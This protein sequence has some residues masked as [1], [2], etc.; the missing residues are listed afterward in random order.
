MKDTKKFAKYMASCAAV[1]D[2][3][4]TDALSEIYWQALQSYSDE[5][6]AAAFE[7]CIRLC[8]FFPKP[9]EIIDRID[10]NI[11]T[12][13]AIAW[14]KLKET[15]SQVGAYTSVRFNDPVIHSVVRAMG[16]WMDICRMD[17]RDFMFREK[18]FKLLYEGYSRRTEHPE[19]LCGEVEGKNRQRGFVEHIPE[20]K[21]INLDYVREQK[22][23]ES[24]L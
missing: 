6:V 12:R 9:G 11:G 4:V 15:M 8:R 17:E 16:G 14:A 20:V 23:I 10:G 5:D 24:K 22:K 13:T 1:F 18:E 19:Y 7:Q 21:L 3:E 2:K